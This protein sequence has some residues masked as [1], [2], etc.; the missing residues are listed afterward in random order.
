MKKILISCMLALLAVFPCQAGE[1][2]DHP[3]T[4]IISGLAGG[5]IDLPVRAACSMLGREIGQPIVNT[6]LTGGEGEIG[7]A[8][9]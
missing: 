6:N 5:L 4:C 2:P 7:R 8:H 3:I 1:Y 9:V